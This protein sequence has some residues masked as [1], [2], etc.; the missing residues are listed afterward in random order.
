MCVQFV[1]S[2]FGNEDGGVELVYENTICLAWE[3][4]HDRRRDRGVV[5]VFSILDAGGS[6]NGC[7]YVYTHTHT[8]TLHIMGT[9]M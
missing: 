5:C 8:Q 6:V 2:A 9:Q 4:V 7:R 1:H 3:V